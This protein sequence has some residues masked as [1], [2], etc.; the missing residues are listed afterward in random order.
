MR[1]REVKP[2]QVDLAAT[3]HSGYDDTIL[4]DTTILGER[5]TR[6]STTLSSGLGRGQSQGQGHGEDDYDLQSV[7]PF[8]DNPPPTSIG[9]P[10]P[11]SPGHNAFSGPF[12]TPPSESELEPPMPIWHNRRD[13]NSSTQS[14]PR[15]QNFDNSPSPSP[16]LNAFSPN[17]PL[18]SRR[19]PSQPLL[20]TSSSRANAKA[21]E[22]AGQSRSGVGSGPSR[23]S[24]PRSD[25]FGARAG[26]RERERIPRQEAPSGGFRRHE[27]AGRFDIPLPPGADSGEVE[28][29]PPLYQPEWE[30]DSQRG[31]GRGR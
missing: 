3:L 30:S 22:A 17:D 8:W 2:G 1:E 4:H 29:L 21:A 16:S 9:H 6:N 11:S 12:D 15:V 10:H 7:S 24:H 18:L 5:S 14:S 23:N 26:D 25:D 31:S 13:S 20:S 28:D 27:D 19:E